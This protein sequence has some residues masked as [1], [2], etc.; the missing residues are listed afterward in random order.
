M[1]NQTNS[2]LENRARKIIA[3]IFRIDESKITRETKFIDDLHAKSIDT[4][5]LIAALEGEFNIKIPSQEIQANQTVGQAID[6]INK[7]LKGED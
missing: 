7:K 1:D 4:I 6:Y 2:S 5:A 3:G